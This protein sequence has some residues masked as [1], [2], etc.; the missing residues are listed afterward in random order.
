MNSSCRSN[1]IWQKLYFHH[2]PKLSWH[3]KNFFLKLFKVLNLLCIIGKVTNNISFIISSNSEIYLNY[4]LSRT[5][6]SSTYHKSIAGFLKITFFQSL[7]RI[8]FDIC[9]LIR[10]YRSNVCQVFVNTRFCCCKK[11]QIRRLRYADCNGS[12]SDYFFKLY[13]VEEIFVLKEIRVVVLYS[14]D[15]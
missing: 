6:L 5:V 14:K 11:K 13:I 7:I 15:G 3:T 8:M 4:K 9:I 10:A 1:Y 2:L 12:P